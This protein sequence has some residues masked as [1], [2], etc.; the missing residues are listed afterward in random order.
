MTRR[1]FRVPLTRMNH[2]RTR[3]FTIVELLIVIVVIAILAAIT[4]V[5][6]NGIQARAK[7]DQMVSSVRAYYQAFQNYANDN[8]GNYPT[9][10]GCLGQST[11]YTSNPC[12]VGANSYNYSTSLN[13]A[14]APYMNNNSPNFPTDVI[15]SGSNL[16]S[17]IF[18]FPGSNYMAFPILNSTSC[19]TIAGA[20]Q[21]AAQ[22]WGPHMFC[23]INV[24]PV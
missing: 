21:D 16:S 15:T 12:Y 14:L 2:S 22:Q 9:S 10:N 20:T 19:P 17:G 6:Y 4:I 7:N 3:G 13:N 18:Y 23:R 24:R 5:A 8:A 11:Y 1:A